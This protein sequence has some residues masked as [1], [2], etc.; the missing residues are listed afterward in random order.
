MYRLVRFGTTDIEYLNQVDMIGGGGTPVSY[1]RLP[2]GGAIDGYA[3]RQMYPGAVERTKNV[4]LWSAT[5]A[6]LD[7]VY[8]ALLALQGKR[9]RLYRRT[10]QGDI[11]WQY[12]RL[13]AL[14]AERNYEQAKYRRIQDINLRF[15]TQEADWRGAL[16]TPGGLT[17]DSGYYFDTGLHFDTGLSH[18]LGASP[19]S[20]VVTVGSALDLGRAVV[21]NLKITINAGDAILTNPV[22]A[23]TGGETL[24]YTGN[25]PSGGSLVIDCGLMQ[26]SCT[27]VS[28]AYDNLTFAATADMATWF[29]LLAGSNTI[30][31]TYTGGGTGKS[32]SLEYYEAW[33]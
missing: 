3:G 23:R 16:W 26:V 10:S 17:F 15:V 13:A 11:H 33:A 14:D 32:I 28:N 9:D 25:I 20:W 19:D 4:R 7:N 31:I 27:G 18:S 21:R 24:T 22:I 1:M 30:T 5:E 8:Y 29:T 6:G 2:G 12:A